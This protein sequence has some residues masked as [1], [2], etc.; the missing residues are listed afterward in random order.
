MN[1]DVRKERFVQLLTGH[2]SVLFAYL[3]ALIG[4]VNEAHNVLQETN[5]VLW[6]RA[7]D[8]S[9]G[10]DFGAWARR[11]AHYQVL[12]YRRDKRRDRHLFDEELLA[13]IAERPQPPGDDE[14]RRL[15]LRHCLAE[16]PDNLR[17]L[18]S[19]R[20]GSGGS[21]KDLTLRLGKSE[22]AVKVALSRVRQKL[23]VCIEKELA[24][25]EL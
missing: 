16:L 14:A 20:Y 24:A 11:I 23:M 13:Q 7:D 8:F 12:A 3:V 18:I 25:G 2:Q 4:D 19:Q 17:V 22:G 9:L 21:I 6:R 5:L 1:D 15:A 10:T